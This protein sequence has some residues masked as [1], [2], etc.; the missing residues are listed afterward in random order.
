MMLISSM[1][2]LV[3]SNPWIN[4]NLNLCK[5]E[6]TVTRCHKSILKTNVG[7]IF[8]DCEKCS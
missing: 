7:D 1:L 3:N 2:K 4:I 5:W 8:K 6:V